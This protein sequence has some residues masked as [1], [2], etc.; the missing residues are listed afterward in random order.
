MQNSNNISVKI[1][2][3]KKSG[4]D[5]FNTL[6][7][8]KLN[9]AKSTS[10]NSTRDL[11]YMQLYSVLFALGYTAL[12]GD[13]S[14][15]S[16]AITRGDISVKATDSGDII[17]AVK[18]GFITAESLASLKAAFAKNGKAE[19]TGRE[20]FG[21]IIERKAESVKATPVK[22]ATEKQPAKK[23]ATKTAPKAE[24]QKQRVKAA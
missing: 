9:G 15:T 11:T 2:N 24:K 3:P 14:V 8:A 16:G 6:S 1:V 7:L 5:S 12:A 10:G 19:F 13:K 21:F 18:S 17:T 23:L 22:A 4:G 20:N